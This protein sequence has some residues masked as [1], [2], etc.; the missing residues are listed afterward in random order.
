MI[1]GSREYKD[2]HKLVVRE[3][4]RAAVQCC[5]HADESC[6]GQME[7][8]N[9]SGEYLGVDDFMVLCKSHHRRYD[10]TPELVGKISAGRTGIEFTAEH[11]ASISSAQLGVPWTVS[12]RAAWK[13]ST[14]A[15]GPVRQ[16]GP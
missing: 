10:M 15:N 6:K 8:A 11:R 7:W 16:P 4:E 5:T 2:L 13:R 1:V 9:I 3:R 12:R 14:A